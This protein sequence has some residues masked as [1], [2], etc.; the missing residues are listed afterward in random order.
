[1]RKKAGLIVT[2]SEKTDSPLEM[3]GSLPNIALCKAGINLYN[4]RNPVCMAVQLLPVVVPLINLCSM[5]IGKLTKQ[6][7][8]MSFRYNFITGKNI[9]I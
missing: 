8:F 3:A 6:D 7:D 4:H 9:D 5:V 2:I 1:M